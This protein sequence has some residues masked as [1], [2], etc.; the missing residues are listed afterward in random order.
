MHHITA[1]L[2]R[3][4]RE[5]ILDP[6][7]GRLIYVCQVITKSQSSRKSVQFHVHTMRLYVIFKLRHFLLQYLIMS[8]KVIMTHLGPVTQVLRPGCQGGERGL[9]LVT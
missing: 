2:L 5:T 9:G 1:S 8:D 3:G 7:Y 6:K 4:P